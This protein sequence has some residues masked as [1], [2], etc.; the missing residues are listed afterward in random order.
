MCVNP[1][2]IKNARYI[3]TKKTKA[4]KI[5]DQR[6]EYIEV[7]CGK[8]TE[9]RKEKQK[10][11]TI[12]IAEENRGEVKGYFVTL[13][14]SDENMTKLVK[15]TEQRLERLKTKI[16]EGW[17]VPRYQNETIKDKAKEENEIATTAIKLF[18]E[19]WRKKY[20]TSPKHFMITEKG[21]HRTKR[22]HLHGIIW[23]NNTEVKPTKARRGKNREND[24]ISKIWGYGITFIGDSCNETTANYIVKYI[25]KEDPE[26]FKPKMLISPG[27][28]KNYL[29]RITSEEMKR[30]KEQE[31]M[32]YTEKSRRTQKMPGYYR[33]KILS[34]EEREDKWEKILDKGTKRIRGKDFKLKNEKDREQI[35]K[36][37]ENKRSFEKK[38]YL[39]NWDKTKYEEGLRTLAREKDQKDTT[40]KSNGRFA[41]K[42]EQMGLW[43]EN[44]PKRYR[45]PKKINYKKTHEYLTEKKKEY[46]FEP[47]NNENPV[48]EEL[49]KN[50]KK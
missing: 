12:R 4:E 35:V 23:Q 5:T 24:E 7:K 28:G 9:C 2:F 16:D 6:K 29:N 27:V 19:R 41:M 25:T 49:T 48:W 8:C 15:Q 13:T 39:K 10:D 50:F 1:K 34:E 20:K 3:E 44:K 47:T 31:I 11:W 18:R 26:G 40:I 30:L 38:E 14:I 33:K 36:I 37:V 45:D 43:K 17:E 46:I 21:H 22:L 42:P 32:M